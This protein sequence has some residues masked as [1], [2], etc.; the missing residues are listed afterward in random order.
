MAKMGMKRKKEKVKRVKY[1][2]QWA[3]TT[4]QMC[5]RVNNG[6]SGG[7]IVFFLEGG[8]TYW[9]IRSIFGPD[10]DPAF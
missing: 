5:V 2:Y 8:G 9:W 4:A 1:L 6:L 10:S 7:E 3:N